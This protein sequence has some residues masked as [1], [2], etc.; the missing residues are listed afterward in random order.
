MTATTVVTGG[1]GF[2][3]TNLAA[4]LLESPG[5]RVVVV[6]NLS[7]PG[8]EENLAW[9]QDRFGARI[10]FQHADVQDRAALLRH[11]LLVA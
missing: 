3:G 7:R 4:Q 2:V 5:N 1:A 6:D 11:D 10:V 8:V 9:L